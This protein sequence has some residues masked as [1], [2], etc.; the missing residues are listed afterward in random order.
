MKLR[1]RILLL[2]AAALLG[3]VVLASVSLNTLRQT[4]MKERTAQLSTL[5][6]LANASLEKLH[7]QE[8]A[9]ELTREAAQKEAKKLIGSLRKDELYFFVRGYT[10]DVNLVHPN[11]KRVG[12]VDA[13]GGKEA[14][15]R[16]RAA[17]AGHSVATLT[18]YGTRPGAKAEVQKLYAIIKFEPWDWIVGFGDYIDDI[19]TAFWRS[20]AILLSIGGALMLVL[21]GLAW[22]MVRSL[23]RQLGGEPAYATEVVQKIGSGDLDVSVRLRAGDSSSLLHAMH[24][25]Q[26][27]L[28]G[29]VQ[30]IRGS[31]E[32]IATASGQIASG[33]QDLS[34]RTEEQASSL[35]E[36]AASMEELT[37]TVKQNADNARQANQ[38]AVSASEVAVR[39]GSVVSQVVGTMG[40]INASSRKIVDIIGV[41]DGIAFQTNILALNAA[42]EAARAGEQGRGFAV[43]ASEVRSLAQRSAAAA[44]EI[45]GLI[46]DSVSKV[47]EGS[48]Q[49]AEAGHT[50][51]EIVD[52]VKRVTD[53]MG[54]ITAASQE[55]TSGIEQINQAI[56]QM[57]QVTQ[58]NAALVEEASAAAQSLQEQA[59]GLVQAVSVFK[60]RGR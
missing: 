35:E 36:T 33:N 28:A 59:G 10:D 54:E 60:V 40:A 44:K 5:V 58:Q 30:E 19:D 32:T 57:D 45:K 50:M 21:G 20:T 2:C 37:S 8:K 26:Q 49:V 15:E 39:G 6:V 3:L 7:A 18:A 14:G 48:K 34:S 56:T 27:S 16:Y 42:V 31:T 13:K 43:V 29:T 12:I 52:S 55:Q 17:L 11:P 25:M 1:T 46:D 4:M 23:Y 9:G 41:I 47:E 22:S 53:I 38:L 24:R 51:E